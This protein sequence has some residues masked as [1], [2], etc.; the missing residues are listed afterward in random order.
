MK[1]SVFQITFADLCLE[2]SADF[3]MAVPGEFKA[4]LT[5]GGSPTDRYRVER[6][7]KPLTSEGRVLFF[8]DYLTAYGE[9]EGTLLV[10]SNMSLNETA[11]GCRLR[12]NGEHSLYVTEELAASLTKGSRLGGVLNGEEMLL[13]HRALLLHSSL[14]C[15]EG[16]GILFSGPCGIGKSTQADLWNRV[17]GDKIINGDRAVVR[18]TDNGF[19]AGGSPWCGSSGIY[20]RD[21]VPVEAIVLL[22]QGPE[23]VIELSA[24][25]IAFQE[26]Y[27]QCIV[28]GWDR[29][30][31][32]RVC[33]LI[34]EL[35]RQVPVY[36]LSCLPD[37]SAAILTKNTVF[38]R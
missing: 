29:C 9:E 35:L 33:D 24:P 25:K 26:I 16:K 19:Y 1:E 14:V 17:F 21:F 18:L 23:N 27:S 4:F 37:P 5:E 34:Q 20:S 31:V 2:F 32:D 3:P 10:F 8:R 12:H 28:H 22:R 36:C 30:F 6:I 7:Y 38:R 13:W 11:P 15:H